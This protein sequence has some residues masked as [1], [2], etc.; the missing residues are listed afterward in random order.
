MFFEAW[1]ARCSPNSDLGRARKCLVSGDLPGVPNL[2]YICLYEGVH[3]R[4]TIGGK[5][6]L[7]IIYFQMLIHVTLRPKK[8]L[9]S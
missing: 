3:L 6:Y 5:I 1:V 8:E 4:L 2:G 7:Y 9:H